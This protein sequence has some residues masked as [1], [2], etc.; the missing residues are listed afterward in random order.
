[1]TGTRE[2]PQHPGDR[3]CGL[4]ECHRTLAP[5]QKKY[6]CEDHVRKAKALRRSDRALPPAADPPQVPPVA[7]TTGTGGVFRML[8]EPTIDAHT[9]TELRL[10]VSGLARLAYELEA[11]SK[12]ARQA[13]A[14][15]PR[16]ESLLIKLDDTVRATRL[17]VERITRALG[18][19][20]WRD[21][22]AKP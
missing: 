6:C 9:V 14:G 22:P 11:E 15:N 18:P 4:D 1:M 7:A 5:G 21:P 17:M 2:A 19:P 8:D 13:L 12:R 16:N 20:T 10:A 3:Q